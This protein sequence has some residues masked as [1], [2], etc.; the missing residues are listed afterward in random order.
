MNTKN[1]NIN[2]LV[3]VLLNIT[4]PTNAEITTETNLSMNKNGV[5]NGQKEAN[6]YHDKVIKRKVS[7]VKICF[8]YQEMVNDNRAKEGK[9][10]DFVP[11]ARKW[12]VRMGNSALI[13]HNNAMY[14]E[15]TPLKEIESR[16]FYEGTEVDKLLFTPYI[17][18]KKPSTHQ[19]LDNEVIVNDFKLPCIKEIVINDTRYIVQ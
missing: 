12:G 5:V 8:N 1:I 16:L 19:G 6:P 13:T 3:N 10:F 15:A 2:E 17:T 11:K 14:L 9:A 18:P 4:T 7:N